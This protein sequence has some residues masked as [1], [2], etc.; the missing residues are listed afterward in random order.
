MD[1]HRCLRSN[2]VSTSLQSILNQSQS[3]LRAKHLAI[4]AD[5]VEA[6]RLGFTGSCLLYTSDAAEACR[7]SEH[8]AQVEP[9]HWSEQ[10]PDWSDWTA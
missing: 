1:G 4:T 2:N 7:Q 5:Q 8:L 3:I 6:L 10:L 9:T